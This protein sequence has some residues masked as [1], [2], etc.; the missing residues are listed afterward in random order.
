VKS[1]SDKTA[2]EEF[3][4]AARQ[5]GAFVSGEESEEYTSSLGSTCFISLDSTYPEPVSATTESPASQVLRK[6]ESEVIR[7]AIR[8]LP[9]R[10]R[11]VLQAHY[12][13]DLSLVSIGRRLNLSK[14]WVS[15]IHAQALVM[16]RKILQE[17]RK[18]SGLLRPTPSHRR[19]SAIPLQA[20]FCSE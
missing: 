7:E 14:S 6:E 1:S 5:P 13:E 2:P 12:Y 17:S 4:E 11:F 3:A 15:R 8:H 10:H 19:G 16:L 9:K 18:P 20:T